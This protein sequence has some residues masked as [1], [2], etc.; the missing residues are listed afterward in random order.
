VF[1]AVLAWRASLASIDSSRYESLAVQ[2][3]ARQNQIERELEGLVA[4]DLRFVNIYQEHALA[5]RELRAQAESLRTSDPAAAD[6]LD[7][8]A[9][10]RQDLARGIIPLFRGGGGV[11]LAAD[12]TVVYDVAYVMAN[13][14]DNHV[15]YGELLTQRTPQLAQ[16]ADS[17]SL[18]LIGVAAI[19]VAALFFLTVAQVTRA[20]GRVRQVFFVGGGLLVVFGVAGFAIVEAL[21]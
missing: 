7:L 6:I 15:E 11:T 17:R 18:G 10:A 5:A 8:E 9:H 19:V 14:R 20:T 3:L 12:G 13:L 16:R 2:Q 4:Q 1:T 21:W